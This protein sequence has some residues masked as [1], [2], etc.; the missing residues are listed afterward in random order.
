MI[1]KTILG[2]V[3]VV[4]FGFGAT[5]E[6]ADRAYE[7]GDYKTALSMLE[8]LANK[9]NIKAQYNLG[10]MYQN[11]FGVEQDYIKAKEW[12]EKSANQGDELAQYNL[13]VFYAIGQGVKQDYVKA[14]EWYEKSANQ[15]NDEAQKNLAILYE[16]GLGVKQ[17]YKT[18]IDISELVI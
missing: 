5:F 3:L 15:G 13:G 11:G 1:K 7:N 16:D 8:D 14:K 9:G 2:L 12:Y 17:N 18:S 4:N 10:L 6:E